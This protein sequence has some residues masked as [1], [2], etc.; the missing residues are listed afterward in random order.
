M[1]CCLNLNLPQCLAA[2]NNTFN[3]LVSYYLELVGVLLPLKKILVLMLPCI[4]RNNDLNCSVHSCLSR[5]HNWH[6]KAFLVFDFIKKI[7]IY[8]GRSY[9]TNDMME[10]LACEQALRAKKNEEKAR[11][12]ESLHASLRNLNTAS[13]FWTQNTDWWR[14]NWLMTSQTVIGF[15]FAK[16]NDRPQRS[17]ILRCV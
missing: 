6:D 17:S 1:L 3:V 15:S 14:F 2:L 7:N 9:C 10:F 12:K 16:Q 13:K 4:S 8:R 11:T 5:V